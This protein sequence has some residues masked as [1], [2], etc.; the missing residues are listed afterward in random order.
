MMSIREILVV[1]LCKRSHFLMQQEIFCSNLSPQKQ[2]FHRLKEAIEDKEL[3]D[4]V[5]FTT[6]EQYD[7]LNC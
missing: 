6:F 2:Q 1:A 7:D 4:A 5:R 3:K